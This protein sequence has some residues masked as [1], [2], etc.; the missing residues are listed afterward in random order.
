MQ[1]LRE[2]SRNDSEVTVGASDSLVRKM[3][4][5]RFEINGKEQWFS[6]VVVSYNAVSKLHEIAY[7]DE[8]DHCFLN[9]LE[10]IAQGDLIVND[11]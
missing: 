2:H 5:H 9:L 6:G 4:L 10:D 1:Y 11:T 8:D 7:D 3:V